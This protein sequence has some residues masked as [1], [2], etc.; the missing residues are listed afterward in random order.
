MKNLNS[1]TFKGLIIA[2]DVVHIHTNIIG[3]LICLSPAPSE[4]NCIGNGN[5]SVLYSTE[6]ITAAT[7]GAGTSV[8]SGSGSSGRVI[9]W[10]E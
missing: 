8:S 7:G 3:G 2:D 5:G 10:W 6:A 4:G 9:A 1:G